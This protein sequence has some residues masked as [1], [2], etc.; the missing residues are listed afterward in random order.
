MTLCCIIHVCI[1]L[2]HTY[3]TC[4]L[5]HL[6][7]IWKVNTLIAQ[8]RH[9]ELVSRVDWL[10]S[11]VFIES[12]TSYLFFYRAIVRN[13]YRLSVLSQI[14]RNCLGINSDFPYF[15]HIYKKKCHRFHKKY[16]IINCM[17]DFKLIWNID[18][19]CV[20]VLRVE[21]KNFLWNIYRRKTQLEICQSI[22]RKSILWHQ[23]GILY[24]S[25]KTQYDT[26]QNNKTR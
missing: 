2:R 26:R 5:S 12:K 6:A 16:L 18:K 24:I 9:G 8:K 20:C 19:I 4:S 17:T 7:L 3:D 15:L 1:L 14:Y 13:I 22:R 23:R 11:R 21:K 25:D 10:H